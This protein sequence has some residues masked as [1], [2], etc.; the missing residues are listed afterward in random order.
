MPVAI[1][2]IILGAWLFLQAIAGDLVGRLL[3]RS[4]AA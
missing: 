2:L 3:A 1:L 4:N